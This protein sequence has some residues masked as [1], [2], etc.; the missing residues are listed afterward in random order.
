MN[1]NPGLS[2]AGTR[3]IPPTWKSRPGRSG[4]LLVAFAALS[5]VLSGSRQVVDDDFFAMRKNFEIFGSLYETL[6]LSYVDPIDPERLMRR[7][8]AAMLEELDPYT[9]FI[10]EADYLEANIQQGRR[11]GS[12]GLDI[13]YRDGRLTV[14][15][16]IDGGRAFRQGIRVGDVIARVAGQDA[17]RLSRGDV[18]QLLAGDPGSVVEVEIARPGEAGPRVFSLTRAVVHADPVAHSSFVLDDREA[19][20]AYIRLATFNPGSDDRVREELQ[21]LSDLSALKAVVLDLRDNQGGL[22]ESAVSVAQ[23]F[24]PA[25]STVVTIR[26]RHP[27]NLREYRTTGAPR[28]PDL[29]VFVLINQRSASASEIVAAA[30]QDHDRGAVVG[31]T[32]FGKGLAQVVFRLPFNT[33]IKVTTARFYTP[34]GRS[35]QSVDYRWQI[36]HDVDTREAADSLRGRFTTAAGRPVRG[37]GGVEPDVP[38]IRRPPGPL[39][40]A[41]LQ[42]GAYFRY[43]DNIAANLVT[44]PESFEPAD[45]DLDAFRLWLAERDFAF[46]TRAD[47]LIDDLSDELAVRPLVER[48]TEA[49]AAN[50][51]AAL[52]SIVDR[53]KG[54]A[55]D[56]ESD[57]LRRGLFEAIVVRLATNP[58]EQ[59]EAQLPHD[60]YIDEVLRLVS[61]RPAYE[62]LLRP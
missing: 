20:V 25:G 15:S 9:V 47:Q 7:G 34:S 6:V 56:R 59:Y 26:G 30:L 45:V 58:A 31:E 19:G 51:L 23:L 22:L 29:P 18:L 55:F 27:E 40:S 4:I 50:A 35:V 41:L 36:E 38:I 62:A 17:S 10:D 11:L 60:R 14:I 28:Y 52:E 49:A 1:R 24:L 39:E 48:A 43:A 12:V 61:D 3:R 53:E 5:L 57:A 21:R 33:G 16:P 2:K 37:G 46:E 54:L 44:R 13:D 42:D 8:V 32:S